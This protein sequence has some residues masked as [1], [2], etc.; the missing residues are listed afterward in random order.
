MFKVSRRSGCSMLLTLF[1]GLAASRAQ[2]QAQ[3][4][5]TALDRQLAHVTL[6]VMGSG[7]ITGSSSG[8][9][10]DGTLQTLSTSNTV[11]LLANLSYVHS[12]LVGLEFNYSYARYT[13]NFSH[14]TVPPTSN[15]SS[16][17]CAG[18][19]GV[20]TRS[21]EYTFGYVAHFPTIVGVIPFAAVG[22]GSTGFTPTAGGGQGLKAQARATY[23][24]T[25]GVEQ[26][27]LSKHF[28]LRAEF[29]Q[30]FFKAPD[31]G[32]NYLTIQ[33]HTTTYEPSAGFFLR[34]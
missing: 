21:N 13:E 8:T 2:A 28:G 6:G 12:P 18:P 31:F 32:Q 11:G 17:S 27:L 30:V 19:A 14:F 29:R 7:M 20:Q 5:E 4:Q 33:A 3:S 1:L 16:I 22:L 34:F 15:C 26:S 25:A 9:L 23:Y 10:S 24:Y